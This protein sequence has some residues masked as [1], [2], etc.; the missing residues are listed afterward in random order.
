MST[1]S[2][3]E[4]GLAVAGGIFGGAFL[5]LPLLVAVV[6]V[7]DTNARRKR[8]GASGACETLTQP[9]TGGPDHDRVTA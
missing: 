7:L 2:R 3:S 4:A 5:G 8:S 1:L 9:L 6:H